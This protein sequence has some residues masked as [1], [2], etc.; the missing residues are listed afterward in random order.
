M[1]DFQF[2]PNK[3]SFKL[4]S[5]KKSIGTQALETSQVEELVKNVKDFDKRAFLK[6]LGV[7][8]LGLAATSLFPKKADALVSGSTP[9]SNVVGLKN[10]ANPNVRINPATEDKQDTQISSL[11]SIDSHI[12]AKGQAQK[13]ASMPV[14]IASDQGPIEV[15][16]S[17]S[18]DSVGLKDVAGVAVNPASDD[19]IVYLRR[20]V[21]LME[22]QATV[23]TRQRQRVVLDGIGTGSSGVTTEL[24]ASLPV[25]ATCSGTVTANIGTG[26]MAAL[27]TL[28]QISGVDGKFLLIDTARNAYANGVRLNLTWS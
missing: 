22:S 4:I 12:P 7:A 10:N 21:K 8:G 20:M 1:K 14:V 9:T 17:F 23:D 28:N 19:A 18:V 24:A 25:T 26:T 13:I 16:G 15:S 5:K 3:N 2:T 11:S 27:T 6:V